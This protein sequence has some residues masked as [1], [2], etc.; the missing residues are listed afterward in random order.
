V[1]A[2]ARAL[3]EAAG[4]VSAQTA[5]DLRARAKERRILVA[6]GSRLDWRPGGRK[7]A[8]DTLVAG[9]SATLQPSLALGRFRS[10]ERDVKRVE[11]QLKTDLGDPRDWRWGGG[12]ACDRLSGQFRGDRT[13]V[14]LARPLPPDLP[15]KLRLI[16]DPVGMI[17]FALSP[18]PLAFER[19][20][21][22]ETVHPVLAY[23]DLLSDPEGRAKE[24]AAVLYDR[25]L[26]K[27]FAE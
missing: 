18:G 22:P 3:A 19:S 23:L 2:T 14:Y 26:A 17:S 20:P 6:R 25:W 5:V 24:G 8:L 12:A 13:H 16:P 21:H 11:A 10:A 4:G 1:G 15:S 9:F 7:E 27:E